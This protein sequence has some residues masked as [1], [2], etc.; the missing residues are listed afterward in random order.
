MMGCGKSTLLNILA[1]P[2]AR[3]RRRRRDCR[4]AASAASG[5]TPRWSSR[6]TRCCRGSPRSRTC[7]WPWTR[8]FPDWPK[9]APARPGEANASSSWGSASALDRRP[10]QL[11]G[12]MR[13]RVAI[14]RAFAIE[15]E[16][17]FLDEPFGALDAL[18]RDAPAAGA[19][20]ALLV[21]G[22]AGHDRDDHQQRR[23]GDSARGPHRA[24]DARA[25]RDAAR[26][27]SRRAS[28]SANRRAARAQ[29]RTPSTCA[30][31]SSRR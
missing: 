1:G 11:S 25:A 30:P 10:S 18:T 17:L 5:A 15:P 6:T 28:A 31:P 14:A 3:R 13:Q 2:A 21:G 22:A 19:G 20:A 12:G 4:R 7:A 24:D 26:A 29:I 23:G 16:V 27:D 9:D 8:R